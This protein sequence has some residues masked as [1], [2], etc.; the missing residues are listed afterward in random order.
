M[1]PVFLL[2]FLALRAN[3]KLRLRLAFGA[4]SKRD[5]SVTLRAKKWLVAASRRG[6]IAH[7]VTLAIQELGLP[8]SVCYGPSTDRYLGSQTP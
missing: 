7:K 2:R 3:H 6:F 1:P 4:E 5:R 8:H